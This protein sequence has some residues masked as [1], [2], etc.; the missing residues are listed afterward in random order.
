M[1]KKQAQA[2]NESKKRFIFYLIS[3][4][5]IL[6]AL[7]IIISIKIHN[8]KTVS[9]LF[10]NIPENCQKILM[11]QI[12]SKRTAGVTFSSFPSDRNLT[13]RISKKY[14]LLFY[15]N[16]GTIDSLAEKAIQT[17][18]RL[19][20]YMPS[21]IAKA[22][23]ID[24][25]P[26]AIP[27]LLDHYE[28]AFYKTYRDKAGLRIPETLS[29]LEDYLRKEKQYATFP[30]ICTG[31]D[32]RTMLALLSALTDSLAG[33]SGY[34]SLVK[35]IR[36]NS[37]LYSVMDIPLS[38][39]TTLRTVLDTLRLWKQEG[40]IMPQWYELKEVDITAYMENHMTSV[41]FMPL[42]VHRAKK[43]VII[44][45]YEEARFPIGD[46]ETDHALIAPVLSGIMFRDTAGEQD[47]LEGLLSAETQERLSSL[48]MLAPVSSRAEA[49]DRQADD[50]RFWAASCAGGPVAG[51]YDDAFTN[52]AAASSFSREIREYLAK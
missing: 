2:K 8:D 21:A 30:F 51:L 29:G 23:L 13:N 6:L 16:D 3:G 49:N 48:T 27:L 18:P 14:D 26:R 34:D 37:S 12:L 9:V 41:V 20:K 33:V 5:A 10:Y 40:L 36:Q 35:A 11:E 50:V 31:S 46:I 28:L 47:I 38:G 4:I 39:T 42:S 1:K 19:Y 25:E 17:D 43:F 24:S 7:G 52:A 15:W 44:K 32:D 45:Y 22:G